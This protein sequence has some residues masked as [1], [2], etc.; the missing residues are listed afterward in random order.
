MVGYDP[1]KSK[2]ESG[3][4]FTQK[5]IAKLISKEDYVTKVDII[6]GQFDFLVQ[7]AIDYMN[8]LSDIIIERIRGIP[9]VSSTQTLISFGEYQNGFLTPKPG[10]HRPKKPLNKN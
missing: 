7:V 10:S 8:S 3:E 6:T 9:G 1:S 2:G 4:E 5:D